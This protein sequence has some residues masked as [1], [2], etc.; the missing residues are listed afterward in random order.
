MDHNNDNINE[1]E[2]F[3]KVE[4]PFSKSKEDVWSESFQTM[5]E[6]DQA[7]EVKVLKLSFARYAAVAS[8]A[9]ML[10]LGLVM[11][12]YTQTV[13]S[14]A[15]E[16]FAHQ[17]P[18]GSMVNLN[19]VSSLSYHPFWWSMDRSM[20]FEGEAFFEVK[21]G[22]DFSVVSE[23][24]TTKVLGTSFNIS[25]RDKAYKVYCKTGKVRVSVQD[26]E[27]VI[28]PNMLAEFQAKL[29][30]KEHVSETEA[31][32]WQSNYFFFAN[33]KIRAVFNEIERR[34][35]VTI[36]TNSINEEAYYSGS[37]EQFEQ[38]DTTIEIIGLTL[39]YQI[40]KESDSHYIVS[41]K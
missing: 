22:S 31:L 11:R 32:A 7:P 21:K 18:D 30:V 5:F 19:A 39:G 12:F 27:I 6:E 9:L 28:T 20:E 24:G 26:E 14:T 33:K 16:Q 10:T 34:Y 15:G 23:L 1:A 13:T 36:N 3:K 2:F 35:S 40:I 17:L 25:T 37:F 8:I 38:P 41:A 29:I 4:T